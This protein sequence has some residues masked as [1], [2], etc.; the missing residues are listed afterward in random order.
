[1][2]LI[3]DKNHFIDKVIRIDKKLL[4]IMKLITVYN[5]TKTVYD[6]LCVQWSFFVFVWMCLFVC[7]CVCVYVCVMFVFEYTYQRLDKLLIFKYWPIST[8][9]PLSFSLSVSLSLSLSLFLSL[10]SPKQNH[11]FYASYKRLDWPWKT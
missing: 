7:I 11:L 10:S 4:L 5:H 6:H 1:M 2:R 3:N 9:L 8:F